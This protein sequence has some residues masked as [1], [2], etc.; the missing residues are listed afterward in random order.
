MDHGD[1]DIDDRRKTMT[2]L[3][4]TLENMMFSPVNTLTAFLFNVK[5]SAS[6][7]LYFKLEMFWCALSLQQ[8]D[9]GHYLF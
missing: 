5:C 3:G 7:T 2:A 9:F 4:K 6:K 8:K 1:F